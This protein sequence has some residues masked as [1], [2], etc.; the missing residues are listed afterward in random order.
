M[1]LISQPFRGF[2]LELLVNIY[3]NE[4]SKNK[5]QLRNLNK[6]SI[7]LM[8]DRIH[9]MK[10]LNFVYTVGDEICLSSIGILLGK[11]GLS[12]KNIF[13]MTE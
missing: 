3:L 12:V 6:V 13:N 10:K 7:E 8:N 9:I 2:S 5:I 4:S 11:I 1:E